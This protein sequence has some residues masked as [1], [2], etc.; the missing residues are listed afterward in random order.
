MPVAGTFLQF[1]RLRGGQTIWTVA[2]GA[3]PSLSL[4]AG[5]PLWIAVVLFW[6]E[7]ML[8]SVVVGA[9]VVVQWRGASRRRDE[10]ARRHLGEI[11][12]LLGLLVGGFNVALGVIGGF[13][14]LIA[15]QNGTLPLDDTGMLFDR[16]RMLAIGLACAA[17]YDTL[18]AP[19]QSIRWLQS[20]AAWQWSRTAVLFVGLF[21]GA[22]TGLV[23]GER[24]ALW[25]FL[26]IRVL[27]DLGAL[28]GR[29]RERIRAQVF[30]EPP[31]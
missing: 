13:I 26:S 14:L 9:R 20:V 31:T 4:L 11:G 2:T 21:V 10:T 18:L 6:A 15:S 25:G 28:R 3:V 22:V 30:E 24:W 19:T 12:R 8:A 7:T 1:L 29:E 27:T 17:V 5:E 23:I 16:L